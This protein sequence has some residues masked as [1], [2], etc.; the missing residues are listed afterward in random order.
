MYPYVMNPIKE[1]TRNIHDSL[2]IFNESR[3]AEGQYNPI[4]KV[5]LLGGVVSQGLVGYITMVCFFSFL[6]YC[7]Q[8]SLIWFFF[9]GRQCECFV[10]QFL[11][12]LKKKTNVSY[13]SSNDGANGAHKSVY[14]YFI[15]A[16]GGQEWSSAGTR[17]FLHDNNLD[18]FFLWRLMYYCREIVNC[19]TSI[20]SLSFESH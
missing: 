8:L 12:G 10:W 9:E 7:F 4:F 15:F 18:S 11:E 3:G 1:R 14:S 20:A 5:H 17:T 13:S 19:I 6:F 2:N 16:N